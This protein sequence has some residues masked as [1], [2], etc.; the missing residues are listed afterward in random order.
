M[1]NASESSSHFGVG[2]LKVW[3]EALCI[4]D[5]TIMCTHGPHGVPSQHCA[6]E[7]LRRR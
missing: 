3:L 1:T 2:G 6:M 7:Q 5:N 4:V